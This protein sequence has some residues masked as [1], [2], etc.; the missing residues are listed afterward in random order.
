MACTGL[1]AA[2]PGNAARQC[3]TCTMCCKLIE[4]TELEKPENVWCRHCKPGK[5]C[6]SYDS[7]PSVCRTFYCGWMVDGSLGDNWRP[8]RAKFI[9]TEEPGTARMFIV[10]DAAFAGAWRREPYYARIKSF[11]MVPGMERQQVVILTG[12]KLTLLVRNG[13][14][15]LGDYSKGDRIDV[16]YDRNGGATTATLVRGEPQRAQSA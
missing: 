6:G 14:F 3:G 8:D 7:R 1:E 15:D 2:Q 16:T 5:G 9:I 4:V 10:C 13:E 11:L 12:R